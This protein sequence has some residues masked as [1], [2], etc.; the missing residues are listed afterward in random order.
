MIRKFQNDVSEYIIQNYNGKLI[1]KKEAMSYCRF[2]NFHGVYKDDIL[3]MT[4][5]YI[6]EQDLLGIYVFDENDFPDRKYKEIPT[7]Q[8][9]TRMLLFVESRDKKTITNLFIHN[10]YSV[11]QL[12][13]SKMF[14]SIR[15][16]FK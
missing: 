4:E 13:I 2:F 9:P 3:T 12:L 16:K 14:N 6:D 10:A 7:N 1:T 15:E 5:G 11:N 8:T